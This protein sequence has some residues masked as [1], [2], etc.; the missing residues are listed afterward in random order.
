[1]RS[2]TA[3]LIELR[4]T[5]QR[6]HTQQPRHKQLHKLPLCTSHARRALQHKHNDKHLPLPLL[7]FM[8]QYMLQVYHAT[9][10]PLVQHYT[11]AGTLLN[12]DVKQG[13]LD[14]PAL[15]ELMVS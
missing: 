7:L 9:T 4:C 15:K 5:E 8:Q 6:L 3:L 10:A 1:L 13:I 2:P 14:A 12:F 11:A